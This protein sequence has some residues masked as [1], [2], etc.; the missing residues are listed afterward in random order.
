MPELSLRGPSGAATSPLAAPVSGRTYVDGDRS[1]RLDFGTETT[2]TL[3]NAFGTSVVQVGTGEWRE[4]TV[5]LDTTG[6]PVAA[7]G[8]WT[9]PNV[10]SVRLQ[11]LESPASTT[12]T[13][14]FGGEEVTMT[15]AR[16]GNLYLP[17]EG[18]VFR[19]TSSLR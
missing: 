10:Y 19:G 17:A 8:A 5:S 15:L 2:L 12:L 18:P 3:V 4:G 9:A 14:R 13:F 6:D 11:Y 7:W 16:R 1:I